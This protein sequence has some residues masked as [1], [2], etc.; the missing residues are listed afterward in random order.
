M[1]TLLEALRSAS[2]A[3]RDQYR[4]VFFRPSD[5]ADSARLEDLLKREHVTVIDHLHGQLTELVRALNPAI[6]FAPTDLDRAAKEHLGSTPPES[7]GVWV[8]YPWSNRLVH[9]LDE[10]EFTLVRTDRNRNK[11]TRV[12]Q[13]LLAIKRVGVIGLSVGQSVSLTMAQERSFGELRLA[14]FDTLELSN[15]NRIRSGVH[16]MGISKVVNTA[17]EIAEIDPFL[18]VTC[19]P[20]GINETNIDRFLTEGGNL[21]L[22][23]EECDSVAVKIIA[24]QKAKALRIPVVMDTSDRGLIDVER[25]DLEPER[26]ILHGLVDHLDLS[27]AA[28]ARTNEEKLPF[29]VPIIGLDTMSTR[30]K[31]SMLEIENSVTTWPQLASAVVLGGGLVAEVHRRIA[32]GQFTAS[33]RW[34]I[35]GEMLLSDPVNP[36]KAKHMAVAEPPSLSIEEMIALADLTVLNTSAGPSI[37]S[38]QAKAL[39]EAGIQAPSAGNLQPWQFLLYDGRLLVFHDAARGDSALDGGRLIPSVDMGTCLENIRL[40]AGDLGLAMNIELYPLKGEH[41]LV[42]SIGAVDGAVVQRD[43][44]VDLLGV[45]CTN[46]KKGDARPMPADIMKDLTAAA[47]GVTGCTAHFLTNREDM[48]RMAVTI[49]AAERMR[50]L[51]PVGH[52]ELFHKEMRWSMEEAAKTRDGLD[53]PT[54]ELKLTEEVGFRVAADR[55]AMD[56]LHQWDTGQAFMKLAKEGIAS[57]SAIVLISAEGSD[58]RSLLEAGRAVQRVWLHTAAHHLAAHPVSAPILLA[59]H[60]RSG[61]GSGFS[62]SD[63]TALLQLFREVV[64]GFGI[65]H[66]EPV[67]MMRLAFAEAP[68]AR[69]LRRP[70]SAFLHT[71]QTT[72][73]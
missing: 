37:S 20:K 14:D 63:R 72:T 28:Q 71:R 42:A 51:N 18:K 2:A 34:F 3:D 27:L 25:F 41:R 29:V 19:Y 4:P 62:D 52:R 15:L 36:Q 55:K 66:R 67:F 56:L 33:G 8:Y 11:I 69:S 32:L 38:A 26:P 47:E 1:T 22:L 35:D 31:A 6:K 40:K 50:V 21:D 13:E 53:I 46:R 48:D 49:G 44:L 23:I 54:M 17:R 65:G 45:R 39:V 64:D 70:L 5:A 24:R 58:P 57:S 7:Y 30:M 43:P 12:E 68:S 10:A 73:A 59:H 60:V 16:Q 9:L 61:D